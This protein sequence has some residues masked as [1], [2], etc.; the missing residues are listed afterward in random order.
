MSKVNFLFFILLA[1]VSIHCSNNKIQ[2]NAKKNEKYDSIL[3]NLSKNYIVVI[4]STELMY[5]DDLFKY[6]KIDNKQFLSDSIKFHQGL[7]AFGLSDIG[8]VQYLLMDTVPNK[9][10]MQMIFE[11]H[12]FQSS[13]KAWDSSQNM[14]LI[15]KVLIHD[16]FEGRE[17][18]YLKREI[19][20]DKINDFFDLNKFKVWFLKNDAKDLSIIRY[21]F[22]KEFPWF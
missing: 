20:I 2:K 10:S 14:Y 18:N 9:L 4:E 11:R 16:Y 21:Q 13:I 7:K 19:E 22:N 12:P 6:Y 17:L 8:L 3:N 1:L 5:R 15:K